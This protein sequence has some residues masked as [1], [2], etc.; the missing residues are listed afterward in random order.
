MMNPR[1]MK[2][3]LT[4]ILLFPLICAGTWLFPDEPVANKI[5]KG[6]KQ[7]E[8]RLLAHINSAREKDGIP[9]VFSHEELGE[10]AE[11]HN[12]EM[13]KTGQLTHGVPGID[14]LGERLSAAQIPFISSGENLAL[15]NVLMAALIHDQFM[16][17]PEHRK[18]IL[19]P[20]FTH[21]GIKIQPEKKS[22]FIT[23]TFAQFPIPRSDAEAE[24][25]LK[26]YLES[27]FVRQFNY[28]FL[29]HHQSEAVVRMLA[30]NRPVRASL[31]EYQ[32]KWG[33]FHTLKIVDADLENIKRKLK[34]NIE[35]VSLE[36]LSLGVSLEKTKRGHGTFYSTV[37]FLFG[38]YF[39]DL[40]PGELEKIF[41]NSLNRLRA[42]TGNSLLKPETDLSRRAYEQLKSFPG[43]ATGERIFPEHTRLTFQLTNPLQ[44]PPEIEKILAARRIIG[45]RIGISIRVISKNHFLASQLL[46]CLIFPG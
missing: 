18:N 36:A 2:F 39:S 3:K 38:N 13:K 26:E 1:Q 19:N 40:T 12:E 23:E 41:L 7:I 32:R 4:L 21:C 15:C 16:Q 5:K 11:K 42:K 43:E 44:V 45:D 27:W 35:K 46:V 10:I 37:A 30:G 6:L 28:R 34:R 14:S 29:F 22:F 9:P 31:S 8:D 24:F 17:S 25:L 33:K 20:R